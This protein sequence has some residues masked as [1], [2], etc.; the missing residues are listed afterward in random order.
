MRVCVVGSGG[1]EHALAHVLGRHHDVVVTPGNPGIG[2]SVPTP[3]EEIEADLTVIGPEAPLVAGLADRLRSAGRLVFGPGAD[4]ARL[5]GSKAWMKDLLVDAGVPTAGHGTFDEEVAALAYLDT[6]GDLFVIKTDGLAAGKGVLVTTDR[7]EAVDAVRS[8]LSGAAFGEAGRTLVI[9]EGLTGPELSIL[10]ICD[11]SSAVA[12]APAQDFK[13]LGDGD[14][15]PNTG[16]MGAY[17]PVPVATE[18]VVG[19]LMADAVEPTLAALRGRGIDYRGV[20]Y[21]GLMFTPRGPRV[22]EYN[23]R[24][25]DPETQ[26]VLLRLTSDLGE[27]LAA[28]AGGRLGPE[29]TFDDGAAVAV[30]CASEGYPSS[31]RTGDRISGLDAAS[32]VTG[33]SVFA[34]GV[35]ADPDGALVTAGGRVFTVTGRGPTVDEARHRAYEAVAE[36]SWPGMC[37]RT[38]IAAAPTGD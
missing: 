10:A 21:C 25:G 17:S 35:G 3:P 16:G 29:P 27:L 14:A 22:L 2:G 26:V 31:P 34:A 36:I 4:G 28:A 15:G 9:E 5:E 30:V 33:V 12:L 11:G 20:L 24:F 1:R 13:R 37:H 23:V 19:S 38:D 32:Q 7:A 6:M 18:A 8:Y